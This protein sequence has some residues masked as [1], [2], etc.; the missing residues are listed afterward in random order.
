MAN[1]TAAL[2]RKP[3]GKGG[4][5]IVLPVDGGTAIYEGTLV[6]QLAGTGMLVPASTASSGPAIGVATHDQDNSAGSDGDLR[7]TVE[8]DR[9]FVFAN[10]TS[11][12]A[13]SEATLIGSTVYAYD[14]HTVYDN[15]ASGTLF[16]AGMFMGM[17]PDGTVRVYVSSH[18]MV[19]AATITALTDN[20][21]GT[22]NN[23][24]QA[25]ADPTDTPATADALRDDI[26]ANL[27][28][29]IRNNFADLAAKVN[30]IRTVLRAS[31]V[32]L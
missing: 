32:M 25:M 7:C 20:S 5:D 18:R 28:P 6:A 22:A 1:A 23:T 10:G 21:A 26:V 8:T 4:R 17:E 9:I 2:G 13:C 11:T 30:E 27:L 19:A 12:D 24:I 3:Y 16:P 29:A 31:G 14:D 15:D